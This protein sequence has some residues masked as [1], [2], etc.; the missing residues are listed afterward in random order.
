MTYSLHIDPCSRLLAVPGRW[1]PILVPAAPLNCRAADH[2]LSLS[3]C[4]A[5]GSDPVRS[6]RSQPGA[7]EGA[8]DDPGRRGGGLGLEC[9]DAAAIDGNIVRN[10]RAA[11][12][13]SAQVCW[14]SWFVS[15]ILWSENHFIRRGSGNS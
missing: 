15:N 4:P 5:A 2:W 7:A 6:T 3:S 10:N 11:V 13:H 12:F 1:L 9:E 14:C 8:G